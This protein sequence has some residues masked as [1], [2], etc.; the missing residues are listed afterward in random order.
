MRLSIFS[1]P[2][3]AALSLC[4]AAI[5]LAD[6]QACACCGTYRVAHVDQGDTLNLRLGPGTEHDVVLRLGPDE[7]CIMK[8]GQRHGRW[9]EVDTQGVRGWVHGGYLAYIP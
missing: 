7:G 4:L 9:V 2:Y 3:F 1:T 8:T 6:A 5:P